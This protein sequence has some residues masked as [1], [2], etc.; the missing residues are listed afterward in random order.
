LL[1]FNF[2]TTLKKC[3]TQELKGV[4]LLDSSI[5]QTVTIA[6]KTL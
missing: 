3:H 1:L 2:S 5:C 4:K 6:K